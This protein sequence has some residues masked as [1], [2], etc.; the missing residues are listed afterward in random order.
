MKDPRVEKLARVM[1][2][3]SL[4]IRKGQYMVLV[5][6]PVAQPLIAECYR[7]ALRAGA[8]CATTALADLPCAC[9]AVP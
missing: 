2:K 1:I 5:G 9:D 6:P 8:S 7:E 3:Y 4:K